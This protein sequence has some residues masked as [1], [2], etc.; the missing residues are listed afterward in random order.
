MVTMANQ[1][2]QAFQDMYESVFESVNDQMNLFA[3]FNGEASLT[4]QELLS[5]M[6]SQVEGLSQWADNMEALAD[7]GINQGLLKHLADMGPE[8]AGY[9]SAF[10]SM[11]D[12]ELQKANELFE[13]SLIL[14]GETAGKVAEAY[15]DAGKMAAEGY[16]T[17][18]KEN[19]QIALDTAEEMAK[20]SLDV[21]KKTLDINSPSRETQKIGEFYVEGLKT[22]I[23]NEGPSVLDTVANLC[24]QIISKT[25]TCLPEATFREIGQQI[26]TG[27]EAGIRAG[28]SGVVKAIEEMCTKAVEKAKAKLDIHSPSRVFEYFG[29]MSGEGYKGGWRKSMSDINAVIAASLPENVMVEQKSA[30]GAGGSGRENADLGGNVYHINQDINVY[31]PVP[32]LMET[33]MAFRR[34]QEEAA[35]E[36]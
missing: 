6:Q 23:K 17:G 27:L 32:D 34:S 22:G 4:T 28:E 18:I 12:E 24:A 36:W 9:V 5:N 10:V 14:P 29:E 16:M 2:S 11:T 7:R 26:P 8:G 1:T 30:Y 19:Q 31:A 25:K 20:Q 21:A 35:R 13:Q 3:K 33:E 15:E